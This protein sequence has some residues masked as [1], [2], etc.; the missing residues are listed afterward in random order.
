MQAF[1][2]TLVWLLL[3]AVFAA[4][5]AAQGLRPEAPSH[6]RLAGCHEETGNVPAPGPASHSCCQAGHHP[7][8]LQQSSSSRPEL[9]V[10]ALAEAY[11][12]AAV[13]AAF[14]PFPHLVIVSGD[15]PV[16]SPLRV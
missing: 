13:V 2:K 16:V 7:A 8:I 3:T 12:D 6:E 1:S 15:P 9:Q 10:F 14:N 5:L 4:P 11:Q